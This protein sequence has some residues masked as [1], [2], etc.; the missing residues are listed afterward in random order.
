MI[1]LSYEI[2]KEF[3][4]MNSYILVSKQYINKHEKIVIRCPNNHIFEMSFNNFQKGQR[5]KECNR[6]EK[7]KYTKSEVE[8]ILK[9]YNYI[10][11]GDYKNIN[12]LIRVK[13]KYGHINNIYFRNF[14]NGIRCKE[15]NDRGRLKDKEGVFRSSD[16][17]FSCGNKKLEYSFVKNIIQGMGFEYLDP[18]YNG[19]K[20]KV[21][22][23]C[24]QGHISEIRFD[25]LR[26]IKKCPQCSK[27]EQMF[28]YQYVKGFIESKGYKILSK[29]YNGCE[30]KLLLSCAN[31]HNFL[32]T[33]TNFKNANVRCPV[34]DNSK[35]EREI[36]YILN[37]NNINYISQYKFENCRDK[38]ELPFDF[39][40]VDFNIAI[41]FD[42][43]QHF[44]LVEIFKN[45]K[46][47]IWH[48]ILKN[49]YCEDNNIK[50]LRIPYWD[51][52]DME[53]IILNE[54]NKIRKTFND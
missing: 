52:N 16:K 14:K 28:T 40:L 9:K 20:S 45:F 33:F 54:I 34:C 13:C 42:G 30:K 46:E 47:T 43:K 48:D 51:F 3:I 32:C 50:L 37:K 23:K 15:C 8:N 11:I 21:K 39:Y 4:E 25:R 19:I 22:V 41:E 5:C 38:K 35:G 36:A 24:K 6:L 31:N 53:K 2:V 29:K 26:N 18:C 49:I 12:S 7:S 1:K 27:N 44:E 10:L 17:K